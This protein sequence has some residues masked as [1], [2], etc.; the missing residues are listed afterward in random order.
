MTEKANANNKICLRQVLTTNT[1]IS[2]LTTA[3]DQK[4]NNTLATLHSYK[5]RD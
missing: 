2:L 4:K 5:N 1:K 3:N